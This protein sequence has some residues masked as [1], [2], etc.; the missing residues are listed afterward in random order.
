[1][2]ELF[3]VRVFAYSITPLLLAT[4]HL[5]LDR[6]VRT[7]AQRIELFIVY[8][9]AISV[10]ANGLGGAFGHLFLSDLIAEGVGWPTGSP[11]Q[12]EM[13]FA[14]LLIGVLGIMAINRRDGF[15]TAAILATTILG[16][17]ATIVHIIDIAAT[18]N[19]SPGNTIINLGNL[20]DPALLIGLTWLASRNPDADTESPTSVR[21]H[22]RLEMVAGMAAAGVGTG[23]GIGYA[24]NSLFLWTLIGTLA[25]VG[26][27]IVLSNRTPQGQENLVVERQLDVNQSNKRSNLMSTLGWIHTVFGITALLAGSAVVVLRKGTR[28]HRTLG[29]MYLTSMIGLNVTA[30]FIYRLFGHFGPFHWLAASSLLTLMAGLIPVFT[31]RPKGLWLERHDPSSSTYPLSGWWRLHR[32]R[33]PVASLAWKMH[34]AR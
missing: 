9:L 34:S 2:N 12:L 25:G 4:A 31:R 14:N 3:F 5:L 33:S 18:G 15:R 8:L 27:G 23:F 30:L 32:L 16:V 19:L 17:G 28:W 20:L 26:I 7:T 21:W 29:H 24:L 6:Q 10:G 11:F 13:G 1:M 22:M